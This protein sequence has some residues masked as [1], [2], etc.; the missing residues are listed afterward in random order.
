MVCGHELLCNTRLEGGRRT[1]ACCNC[2]G[3][4]LVTL[5]CVYQWDI[6]YALFMGLLMLSCS[7]SHACSLTVYACRPSL[8]MCSVY[9]QKYNYFSAHFKVLN[10]LVIASC[11]KAILI[12]CTCTRIRLRK[13]YCDYVS[14]WCI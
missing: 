2:H 9:K 11:H 5:S 10:K 14:M 8:I 1:H 6:L 7:T 4:G 3:S 13:M 12:I